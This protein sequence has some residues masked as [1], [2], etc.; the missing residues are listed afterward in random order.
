MEIKHSLTSLLVYAALAWYLLAALSSFGPKARRMRDGF[1]LAAFLTALAAWIYRWIHAGHLPMQNL[2]EVFLTLGVLIWPISMFCRRFQKIADPAALTGDCVLGFILLF[3]VGFV[4]PEAPQH[5]PPALQSWLFGPHVGVYMLS[6]V[7]LAKAAVQSV[8]G[9]I[10][11]EAA[12][13]R[14]KEVYDLVRFGFPFLTLGLLLGSVWGKYAWGDWWGWDPKELWSLVC[15]L[16]YAIYLHYRALHGKR[17]IKVNLSLSA[18]G[19][20]CIVITLLLVN[21]SRRF[22]GLHNYAT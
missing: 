17:H 21:L 15:W 13:V 9:L 20:V 19:F 7:I 18:L 6:Y 8:T 11:E 10:V 14:E 2:F 3:P 16:V 5:L 1:F 22:P 4:F 12:A